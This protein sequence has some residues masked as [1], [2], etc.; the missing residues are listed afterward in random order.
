[1]EVTVEGILTLFNE[2]LPMNAISPMDMIPF[3]SATLSTV[4]LPANAA[5]ICLRVV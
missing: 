3:F 5:E 2:L 1:M 4:A